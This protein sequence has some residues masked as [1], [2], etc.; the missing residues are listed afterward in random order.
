M[1][2]LGDPYAKRHKG[3]ICHSCNDRMAVAP[4]PHA[5][6]TDAP[7]NLCASC[8][9]SAQSERMSRMA[10]ELEWL[11]GIS[12]KLGIDLVRMPSRGEP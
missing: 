12:D 9:E 2:F 4:Y 5:Y 7:N 11:N 6:A 10:D 1:T 3:V 8:Y